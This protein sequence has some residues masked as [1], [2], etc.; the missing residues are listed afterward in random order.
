[1]L[2]VDHRTI[3]KFPDMSNQ[4]YLQVLDCIENVRKSVVTG[5]THERQ[6]GEGGEAVDSRTQ[7]PDTTAIIKGGNSVGGN[8]RSDVP[9]GMAT[10]GPS[11][12]GNINIS[13]GYKGTKSLAGG[14]SKGGDAVGSFAF[15]GNSA[16]GNIV[17]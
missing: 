12:G 9:G 15:G 3:C 5:Q 7:K 1:M 6:D 17:L 8:A 11:T 16:G 14:D 4:G 10:G 2:N 13:P